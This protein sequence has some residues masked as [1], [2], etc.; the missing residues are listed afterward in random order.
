MLL[1]L[2]LT[3][4]A[5]PAVAEVTSLLEYT[6]A[7]DFLRQK[8]FAEAAIVLKTLQR[9][10][11]DEDALV[12]DLSR[13]LLHSGRREEALSILNQAS[14]RTTHQ[15]RRGLLSTRM[16]VLSRGFITNDTFQVF[17]DGIGYLTAG[18]T[19]AA[20]EKFERALEREPDNVEV[21]TRLGQCLVLDKDE[22]SAAERLRVARRLNPYEPETRLWLGRAM[23]QRGEARE[24]VEELR[25]IVREL[26]LS[27]VAPLWYAEALA[28]VGQPLQG[29]RVLEEDLAR[30]PLHVSALLMSAKL[31]VQHQGREAPTLWQ[32][33]KDL[34][35]AQSRLETY[36]AHSHVRD[37]GE[38]GLP[39][40]PK[41]DE[42]RDE[43]SKLLEEVDSRLETLA[44]GASRKKN[45][46]E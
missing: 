13:A 22:D 32:A 39:V 31:R 23:H 2:L 42:A 7:K 35:L 30:N 15:N 46:T 21:L 26:P 18:R 1:G 11:P 19:K 28:A 4:G 24:A 37:E 3:L 12:L 5:S 29:I 25:P 45:E 33:R 38:M 27:E 43:I 44:T 9:R 40:K 36:Y 16:R 20:R 14:N 8:K 10:H 34:Q 6:E 17:Q 41:P